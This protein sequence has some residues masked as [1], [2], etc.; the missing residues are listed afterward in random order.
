MDQ[1]SIKIEDMIYALKS[2]WKMIVGI[3]L[4]ATILATVKFLLFN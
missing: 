4:I 2:K 3:T 1:E